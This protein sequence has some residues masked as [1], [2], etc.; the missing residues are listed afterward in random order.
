MGSNFNATVATGDHLVCSLPIPLIA[1][2]SNLS[3]CPG[4]NLT[5]ET[6][7]P[8]PAAYHNAVYQSFPVSLGSIQNSLSSSCCY[9]KDEGSRKS[10]TSSMRSD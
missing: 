4:P 3:L 5:I 1:R 7:F 2:A 9:S 6:P 10:S 8:G